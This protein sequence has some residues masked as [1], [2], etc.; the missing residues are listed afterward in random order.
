M[1]DS[2]YDPMTFHISLDI[3]LTTLGDA[4]GGSSSIDK[5]LCR[6]WQ[7]ID[8]TPTDQTPCSLATMKACSIPITTS[9]ALEVSLI[10]VG[11]CPCMSLR[12]YYVI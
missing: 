6:R 1:A 10:A 9:L 4:D 12:I 2:M 8:P 7:R 5:V 11:G 3:C